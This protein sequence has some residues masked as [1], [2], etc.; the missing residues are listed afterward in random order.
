[1]YKISVLVNILINR[2]ASTSAADSDLRTPLHHAV[3]RNLKSVAAKLLENDALPHARDK[4]GTLPLKIAMDNKNDEMCALLLAYMPNYFVRALF[5]GD[6]KREAEFSFHDLLRTGSSMQKTILSILDCMIETR[7]S[8]EGIKV[9]YSLLE[10]DENG[11]TPEHPKF[12]SNSKSPLQIIAKQGNKNIVYHDVVR[13][14]IRRKWKKYAKRRFEYNSFL[15][16]L[17]LFCI[18]YSAIVSVDVSD[19]AVYNTPLQISRAVLEVISVLMVLLTLSTEINQMRRHRLEYFHD[20]FNW[21]D[22]SSSLLLLCVIPLRFTHNN[23]QWYVFAF[24][25][26]LWTIRIFK[27]AAVFRQTGAYAQISSRILAHDFLQF[28]VVFLVIL[29][30]FSGSFYLSLRGDRD[31]MTHIETSSFWR[32]LLVGVRS[33]TEASPVVTYTGDDGYGV[34]SA[35]FML[36]FLFT[37]IVI[38]LNILIAQLSDT[39][40]KVQQDAQRGLEV[41]RAWIVARVELNSFFLGKDWR[42]KCYAESEDIPDL[43][44]VLT[45]WESPPL[46]EMNKHILDIWDSLDSHKMNLLTIQHRMVRQENTLRKIQDQ[47]QCL[48][49][50]QSSAASESSDSYSS[51][52]QRPKFY[53]G[54]TSTDQ[55]VPTPISSDVD[56]TEEGEYLDTHDETVTQR[57]YPEKENL[58]EDI[59]VSLDDINTVI[60]AIEAEDSTKDQTLATYSGQI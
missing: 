4:Q 10:C 2:G 3:K 40:Q 1:M 20:P 25:Y 41:N 59:P 24:G 35:I 7:G 52:S 47:L 23:A 51:K 15:Y 54:D 26:L 9:Y 16:V 39:Y 28:G 58:D 5:V 50:M 46:N 49:T 31:V 21:F 32:I 48:I 37:C 45:K 57:R 17:A 27:F 29:L 56:H 30:A 14:L 33:L 11:R 42:K 36:C 13:L 22:L 60:K 55:P 18:T 8:T 19:P 34:V 12:E 38:L 44:I 53:R 43:K 6:E